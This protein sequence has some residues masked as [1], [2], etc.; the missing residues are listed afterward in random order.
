QLLDRKSLTTISTF[1]QFAVDIDTE[2]ND[3][4]RLLNGVDNEFDSVLGFIHS[5]RNRVNRLLDSGRNNRR[6]MCY[7]AVGFTALLIFTYYLISKSLV[8]QN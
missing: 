8:S 1:Y 7:V 6:L 3:H 2:V 4:N 5:G